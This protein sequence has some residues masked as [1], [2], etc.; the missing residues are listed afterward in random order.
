MRGWLDPGGLDT[1]EHLHVDGT[2][3]SPS[4]NIVPASTMTDE[5]SVPAAITISQL[6]N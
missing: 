1:V 3:T 5:K 6:S 2:A 4:G